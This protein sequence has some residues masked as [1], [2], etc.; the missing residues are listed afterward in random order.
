MRLLAGVNNNIKDTLEI[1]Y[2]PPEYKVWR[3]LWEL[4]WGNEDPSNQLLFHHKWLHLKN[5]YFNDFNYKPY[6]TQ[7]MWNDEEVTVFQ[8]VSVDIMEL[9][10]A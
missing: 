1:S 2:H 4:S 9:T 8:Y 7:V 3:S 5:K 10:T 6:V